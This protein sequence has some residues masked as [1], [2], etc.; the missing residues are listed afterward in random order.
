MEKRT[1]LS[2]LSNYFKFNSSHRY[3]FYL[4]LFIE[5]IQIFTGVLESTNL[6]NRDGNSHLEI[7]A[8]LNYISPY[9]YLKKAIICNMNIKNNK[10]ICTLDNNLYIITTTL[11]Y[12]F[13]TLLILMM[14]IYSARNMNRLLDFGLNFLAKIFEVMM[15]IFNLSFIFILLNKIVMEYYSQNYYSN[16]YEYIFFM[17]LYFLNISVFL[18]INILQI[19]TNTMVVNLNSTFISY[20]ENIFSPVYNLFLICCKILIAYRDNLI[21]L[22]DDTLQGVFSVVI[23]IIFFLYSMKIFYEVSDFNN[24]L[25]F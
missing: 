12:S 24:F 7:F 18:F 19:Q 5:Y 9:Y 23:L 17:L 16:I 21:Y 1:S 11:P 14:I 3:F 13:I 2:V 8:Y 20:K 4:I 10:Y 6:E 25:K 22:K 15:T